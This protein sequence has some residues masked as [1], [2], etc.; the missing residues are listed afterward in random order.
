[1]HDGLGSSRQNTGDKHAEGIRH[2]TL[3]LRKR[4]RHANA[5]DVSLHHFVSAK[6]CDLLQQLDLVGHPLVLK[7]LSTYHKLGKR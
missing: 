5:V 2:I 4:A 7:E 3:G 6:F 1:M